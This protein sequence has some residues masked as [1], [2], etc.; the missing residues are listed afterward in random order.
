MNVGVAIVAGG[1]GRRLWEHSNGAPKAL[2]DF[3]G[4]SLLT[5]QIE[6]IKVLNPAKVVVLLHAEAAAVES[7][8]AGR[9]SVLVETHPLGTAGG[10]HALPLDPSLWI[11]LNIDH[12]SDVD[13]VGLVEGHDGPCTAVVTDVPVVVDEGV[14]QINA[15]KLVS[16]EE[17]P[18]IHV[19]VTTGLYV[20][21]RAEISRHLD[22]S[23]C[24]MPDLIKR[25]MPTGVRV[26][27]HGGVWWDVGTP[28][29]LYE[30]AHWIQGN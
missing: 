26:H 20:F 30:A 1:A 2:A 29:R 9:A 25:I 11:V 14:V 12:V 28:S 3:M 15:G 23:H 19:S 5:Y 8:L 10:L 22:G 13:M 6:R 4:Q 7:H 27:Q 24:D 21:D 17:R 18:T 16:W